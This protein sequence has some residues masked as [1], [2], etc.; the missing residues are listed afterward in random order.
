MFYLIYIIYFFKCLTAGEKLFTL[1]WA[2]QTRNEMTTDWFT[3]IE[4]AMERAKESAEK[5][6]FEL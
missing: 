4:T 5:A 6:G 2:W 1:M 3:H